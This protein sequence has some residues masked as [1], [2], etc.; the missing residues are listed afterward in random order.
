MSTHPVIGSAIAI[1]LG[2]AALG[3]T[4]SDAVT[5]SRPAPAA[6]DFAHPGHNP[7]YPLVPGTVTR[8]RV[9]EDGEHSTEVVRVTHHHR[10]IQG[11]RTTAISDVIRGAGGH[12]VERTT[13]WYATDHGGTVWY[14]GERTATYEGG[15]VSREGSW[16]A[17]RHGGRRGVIMPAHPRVTDAYRQEFDS[18][19]A[20]DQ[21][22]IV[23]TNAVARLRH[24]TFHHAVRSFEWSRLEPGVISVK[25]YVRGI[26]I[27][28]EQDLSGGSE[29]VELIS[30]HRPH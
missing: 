25:F 2:A 4:G 21:G 6:S 30:V 27:V 24:R 1:V 22:W 23:A 26:G 8:L 5:T 12:L 11:V 15:R 7:Y 10:R 13:D 28:K 16:L 19:D 17:G 20:E 3:V 18:G 14:F 29:R 9:T